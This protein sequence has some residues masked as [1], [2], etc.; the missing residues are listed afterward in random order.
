MSTRPIVS[1]CH[2]LIGRPLTDLLPDPEYTS[3]LKSTPSLASPATGADARKWLAMACN[4]CIDR[5]IDVLLESACRNIDEFRS[6]VS[7]F[8]DGGYRVYVVIMAVPECLSLM[9][10]MLRYYKRLPEAQSGGLPLRLTPR[11]VHYETYGITL[12]P[13]ELSSQ[14]ITAMSTSL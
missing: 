10:I 12:P 1:E 2:L 3:I 13:S 7:A 4:W 5:K 6:L 8:R 14:R 11:T 9:G